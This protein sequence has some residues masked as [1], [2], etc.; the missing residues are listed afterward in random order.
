MGR[1]DLLNMRLA[2]S[3]VRCL[4]QV[5]TDTFEV[6]QQLEDTAARKYF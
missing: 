1:P 3:S 2:D 5:I 4:A 6:F